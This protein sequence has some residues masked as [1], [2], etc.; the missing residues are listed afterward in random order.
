MPD[1]IKAKR[2]WTAGLKGL[3][4][5]A[6][7]LVVYDGYTAIKEGLPPDEVIARAALGADK[8]LY[9]GKEILQL[10]PEEKEARS[11]IKRFKRRS[12]DGFWI[13]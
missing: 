6:A 13:Y 12:N 11:L 4:I 1:D 7:P 5:A 10:T 3:G 8:I 2:Y 9:K